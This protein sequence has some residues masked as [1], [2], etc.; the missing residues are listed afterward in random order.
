VRTEGRDPTAEAQAPA[1]EVVVVLVPWRR[2]ED[3]VQPSSSWATKTIWPAFQALAADCDVNDP[4]A[5]EPVT[6]RD[7]PIGGRIR[8]GENA[9]LARVER[10]LGGDLDS[11]FFSDAGTSFRSSARANL[12]LIRE[13][14]GG[15]AEP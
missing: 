11:S 8:P 5:G 15:T 2:D 4:R 1:L 6:R 14:Y 3:A 9:R 12:R 7:H 13:W 10:G